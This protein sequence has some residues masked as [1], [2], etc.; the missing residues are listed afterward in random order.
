MRRKRRGIRK[1]AAPLLLC[2]LFRYQLCHRRHGAPKLLTLKFAALGH[3]NS[4]AEDLMN[5]VPRIPKW[6]TLRSIGNSWAVRLTILIP[7]VGFMIIFNES[8]A[9]RMDLIVEFGNRRIQPLSVPPRLFEM[10][11][12]LCFI[13]AGSVIYAFCCPKI[14]QRNGTAAEFVGNEGP[15][16]GKFAI[17]TIY[18]DIAQ[19][20]R[21]KEFS[22]FRRNEIGNVDQDYSQVL[23]RSE[24]RNAALHIYF[25]VEDRRRRV[26]RLACSLL[27][28]FGFPIL[29]WPSFQVF[30]SVVGILYRLHWPS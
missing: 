9:N 19:S 6:S 15:H 24:L 27:F 17:D 18:E 12:G 23:A 1:G 5:F 4:I 16:F 3:K 11:F 13:A 14:I 8:L 22:D 30:F 7:I 25:D 2:M 21:A 10:Y 28:L 29:L 20:D 26:A